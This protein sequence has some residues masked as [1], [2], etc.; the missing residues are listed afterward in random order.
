MGS[1]I[2]QDLKR[3]LTRASCKSLQ[4]CSTTSSKILPR[5]Y[6]INKLLSPGYPTL[7][8]VFV[9]ANI[10]D[11]SAR[12]CDFKVAAKV[13]KCSNVRFQNRRKTVAMVSFLFIW[14]TVHI[15]RV[16]VCLYLFTIH[17]YTFCSLAT[18]Q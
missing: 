8:E 13:C 3:N 11:V 6:K 5:S 10:S 7:I 18:V 4:E 17:L 15:I 12:T 14:F 16:S 2:L 1:K 9:R